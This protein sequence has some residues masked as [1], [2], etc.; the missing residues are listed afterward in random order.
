[1][2]VGVFTLLLARNIISESNGCQRN[3]AEIQRLQEVPAFLNAGKDPRR[4]DEEEQCDNNGEAG[5]M[6]CGELGS[7]NGPSV[8]EVGNRTV[9]H[10]DHDPLHHSREEH[11]R[12]GNPKEG[13]EYTKGLPFV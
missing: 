10:Q 9:R 8:M 11:K 3:K 5:G 2:W 4:D 7:E 13:V 12:S 6:E 1:M